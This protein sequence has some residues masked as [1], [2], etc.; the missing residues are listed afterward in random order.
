MS[1]V[2]LWAGGLVHERLAIEIT[3]AGDEL[4]HQATTASEI[5]ELI[6]TGTVD[7]VVVH[8]DSLQLTSALID[9][10]DVAGIRLIAIIKGDAD[11]RHALT[12][13]FHETCHIDASWQ[14]MLNLLLPPTAAGGD[15]PDLAF[16]DITSDVPPTPLDPPHRHSAASGE[17]PSVQPFSASV[18]AQNDM[19]PAADTDPEDE[20]RL[21]SVIAVWGPTGAPGRTSVAINVAAELTL[22]GVDVLLID[23]DS[24]GGSIAPRLGLLDETPGFVAVCRLADQELLDRR[25]VERLSP[26]I[27]VGGTPLWV[28]TGVLRPDRW[29]ELSASRIARALEICREFFDV[30][31]VDVGF[32]LER[33]EEISSDLFAAR[34]NAATLTVLGEADTILG[35]SD[36][37]VVGV[38]RFLRASADLRDLFAGTPLIT[39]AN[40]VR[41]SVAGITPRTEV[42]R[43]LER[44]GGHTD[45]VVIPHDDRAFDACSLQAKPLCKVAPK[46]AARAVLRELAQRLAPQQLTQHESGRQK[47]APE[48]SGSSQ[49][50]PQGKSRSGSRLFARRRG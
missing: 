35:V 24:H 9:A 36:G 32:N 21:A 25:E 7:I 3:A 30:I 15:I 43:T 37:D 20:P 50:P 29:P 5:A 40:R 8:A 34:R 45:V 42:R 27:D 47:L 39:V 17:T 4:T 22:L 19:T 26:Q 18:R 16:F 49:S 23:A 11:R 2:A 13:D 31:I 14:S 41:S 38:A 6:R 44:F 46:S 10:C 33:D 28:L 48:K 12:L 1:R